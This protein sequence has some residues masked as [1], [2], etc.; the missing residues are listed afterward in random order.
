MRKTDTSGI[1]HGKITQNSMQHAKQSTKFPCKLMTKHIKKYILSQFA[2][3][4][5][6]LVKNVRQL[7]KTFKTSMPPRLR[8]FTKAIRHNKNSK[9]LTKG[10]F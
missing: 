4:M 10:Q 8:L 6:Q 2:N 3:I 9:T 1:L 7:T 5:Q